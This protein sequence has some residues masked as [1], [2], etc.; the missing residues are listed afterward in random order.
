[1]RTHRH[2]P[3]ALAVV[4]AMAL[5][6][7]GAPT[8]AAPPPAAAPD[9]AD[10][11]VSV[12]EN[13]GATLVVLSLDPGGPGLNTVRVDLRDAKGAFVP[14]TVRVDL[15]LGGSRVA[16]ATLAG[17]DRRGTLAVGHAG[18]ADVRVTGLEGAAAGLDVRFSMDL[19]AS[20]VAPEAL[21]RVDQA[22]QGLR[23]LRET[24]TLSGGGPSV[25]F[26]FEYEA[27]DRVRYTA[28]DARG[29]AHETRLL[30]RDRFDRDAGGAWTRS[31]LG[32]AL[33]VPHS[34]YAHGAARVRLIGHERDGAQDVLELAFVQDGGTY[35]RIW[36]GSEDHLVR[37]YLMMAKG[38]YMT[39]SFSDAGAPL[40]ISPPE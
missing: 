25:T 31:D 9:V 3:A 6:C 17:A 33:K 19:P 36:M 39:G 20:R 34:E 38:H 21:A 37:R 28:I 23:T 32:L 10:A 26:H 40:A 15:D 16:G 4:A 2:G 18:R 30:G 27:P 11:G 1:M 5:A 7:G 24:Q 35:Y 12:A 13:A 14:G 22:M 29:A 8:A